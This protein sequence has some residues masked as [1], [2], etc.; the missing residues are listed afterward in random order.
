MQ[1][2]LS[3]N[4]T[5][6]EQPQGQPPQPQKQAGGGNALAKQTDAIANAMLG[7]L[8]GP[9]LDTTA[10]MLEQGQ[11]KPAQAIGRVLSGLMTTVQQKLTED[12]KDVPPGAMFAAS[13]VAAQAVGEMAG[14]MGVIP[15]QG[16][17]EVIEAGFMMGMAMFGKATKDILP[18]EKRQQY[19]GMIEQLTEG[20]K[21]AMASNPGMAQPQ[22][23][24]QSQGVQ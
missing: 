11:G 16:N 3:K 21:K 9:A 12:N 24:Q 18:P 8:Y 22:A 20:R 6:Q 19:A 23:G 17:G 5:P 1:G 10:Q 13:M 2:I 4:M 15:E 14:R 7:A